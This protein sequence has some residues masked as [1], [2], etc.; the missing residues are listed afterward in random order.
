MFKIWYNLRMRDPDLEPEEQFTPHGAKISRAATTKAILANL[1]LGDRRKPWAD[2]ARDLGIKTSTITRRLAR[3]K[4]GES[5]KR[6]EIGRPY[7]R[8]T[9]SMSSGQRPYSDIGTALTSLDETVPMDRGTRIQ[10][11][12]WLAANAPDAVRVQ[13]IARLEEFERS[14]GQHFGPPPPTTDADIVQNLVLLFQ[15]IPELL[16][17]QAY[18]EAYRVEK[19]PETTESAANDTSSGDLGGRPA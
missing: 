3:M 18:T 5:G 1:A 15:G 7:R 19:E 6:G 17:M 2:I 13:A 8:S 10:H 12:S 16:V 9:L 4:R 14:T 11:L